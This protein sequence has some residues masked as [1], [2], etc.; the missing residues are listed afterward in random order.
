MEDSKRERE[1]E[2]K[3]GKEKQER[4]REEEKVKEQ[5]EGCGPKIE[6]KLQHKNSSK[7]EF[8]KTRK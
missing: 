6:T 1:D 4:K 3:R 8:L 2:R 5:E 7:R